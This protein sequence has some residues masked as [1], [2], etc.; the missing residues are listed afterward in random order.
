M[1]QIIFILNVNI[2]LSYKNYLINL[3]FKFKRKFEWN[4]YSKT[5]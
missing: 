1:I 5:K 3:N 2:A 4:T